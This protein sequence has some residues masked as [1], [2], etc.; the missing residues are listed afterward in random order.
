MAW[1]EK[2]YQDIYQEYQECQPTKVNNQPLHTVLHPHNSLL[3]PWKHVS[4][5]FIMPLPTSDEGMDTIIN[6]DCITSKQVVLWATKKELNLEELVMEYLKH[7]VPHKGIP[8]KV[9]SDQ[10]SMFVSNFMKSLFN[11]LGIEANPSTAYHPQTD[12]QT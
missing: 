3:K 10:G 1:H 2:G 8:H 11:L 7:I 5:N 4:I 12:R 6:V 9:V